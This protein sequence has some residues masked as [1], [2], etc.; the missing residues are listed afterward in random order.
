MTEILIAAGGM[1]AI[2]V[3]GF[4]GLRFGA[5]K[6]DQRREWVAS[7]LFMIATLSP[8]AVTL[9]SPRSGTGNGFSEFSEAPQGPAVS[10][11][12]HGVG[13]IFLACAALLV[14]T[15]INRGLILPA[16]A[17]AMG[18]YAG[19]G[20]VSSLVNDQRVSIDLFYAALA[21]TSILTA[22]SVS[23]SHALHLTRG[24]LRVY[25]W[26]S[27]VL[28]VAAPHL[29]FWDGQGRTWFGLSQLAG[30]TTHPN[31]MG[32][33]AALAVIV[34]LIRVE[35]LKRPKVWHL[36]AAIIALL[37]TQSRGAWL[38]A[39]V[40]I[41]VYLG[42]RT[43]VRWVTIAVPIIML[44][45]LAASTLLENVFEAISHWSAGGDISTLN[46]RTTIWANALEAVRHSPVFGTGPRSFD[47]EYRSKVLGLGDL[48]SASNAHNQF[49]QTLVERGALGLVVLIVFLVVL[50]RS[51]LQVTN[52]TRAGLLAVLTVFIARFA[53]ETPLNISTASLNGALLVVVTV[54]VAAA[55]NRPHVEGMAKATARE[56]RLPDIYDPLLRAQASARKK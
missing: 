11:I 42:F 46:G 54:L 20:W 10:L 49:V 3:A 43:G 13:Y 28:A 7:G 24:T 37:A 29:A 9:L 52:P 39:I 23:L 16:P 25:V 5:V 2:L 38:S 44:L 18:A 47:L 4:Y 51:A 55:R 27:L 21:V 32:T 14:L 56:I 1:L 30:V 53:V 41:L 45:L 31:G 22:T 34:E 15:R 36:F 8:I 35:A 50:T 26:L 48:I 17:L 40:G 33:V 19:A 12:I 6:L